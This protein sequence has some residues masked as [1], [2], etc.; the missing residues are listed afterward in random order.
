MQDDT[1]CS[2]GRGGWRGNKKVGIGDDRHVYIA[3]P[4]VA[5]ILDV[6][7][8]EF[9]DVPL[10]ELIIFSEGYGGEV[11]ILMNRS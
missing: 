8:A 2:L 4:T 7:K 5:Y 1:C 10:S 9:P 6:V 11:I 3:E